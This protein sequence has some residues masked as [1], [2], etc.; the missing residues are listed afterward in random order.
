MNLLKGIHKLFEE[1]EDEDKQIT[2][3]KIEEEVEEENVVGVYIPF[4]VN[5]IN[6]SYVTS[7]INIPLN[8]VS[9]EA[10]TEIEEMVEHI[11]EGGRKQHYYFDRNDEEVREAVLEAFREKECEK[12]ISKKQQAEKELQEAEEK[13]EELCE[14]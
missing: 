4:Y 7:D 9:S 14:E 6:R 13:I 2:N 11:K 12:Y 3:A 5:D 10:F 1:D 8:R